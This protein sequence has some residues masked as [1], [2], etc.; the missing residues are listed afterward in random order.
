[1]KAPVVSIILPT[2]NRSHLLGRAIDSVLSQSFS[3]WELIVWDD[4]S[5]DRTSELVTS[6][7][8]Q[9]I[10]YFY[11]PNRGAA[12]ARNRAIERSNGDLIA[13]LDS[14]DVWSK[15]KLAFQVQV[16]YEHPEID[17][18]FSDFW[19]VQV[20]THLEG[21][22]FLDC[23]VAM[24]KMK[25]AR[26]EDQAL[27]LIRDG[28]LEAL[29]IENFIATDTVL[30]RKS[31]LD[32][33]NGFDESLRNSEDF[34]LWWRL[35]L[36]GSQMAYLERIC[37]TRYKMPENLSWPNILMCEH[38][39]KALDVCQSEALQAGR[40]DLVLH[41]KGSYRNLWQNLIVLFGREGDY[42]RMWW[43]F[44]KSIP[45]GIRPGTFRVLIQTLFHM[46]E[47]NGA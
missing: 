10:Q 42:V 45:Y 36:L 15:E 6:Y 37:L 9:R 21:S 46:R 38:A 22:A 31:M 23:Q 12:Y 30:L 26:F 2:Y 4:G 1:M 35:G 5:M 20:Y 7:S 8:D 32:N 25:V 43:A 17:F 19:N 41:L 40:P 34:V 14:D 18:L 3:Q 24:K 11:E 27:V 13:F 29:A 44:L 16:M 47:T 39:L 28:F 33:T